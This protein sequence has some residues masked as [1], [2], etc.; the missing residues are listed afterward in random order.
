MNHPAPI[1]GGAHPARRLAM[2][3]AFAACITALGACDRPAEMARADSIRADSIAAADTSYRLRPGYIIDSILPV[4]EELRSFRAGL[5]EPAR[6]SG[7]AD[8]REE[9]VRR[10]IDRLAARDTA[11]LAAMALTRAEF[12]SLIYPSSRYTRPPYRTP[13]GL[14][15][16]RIARRRDAGLTRLLRADQPA[17]RYV[18]HRCAATP[19]VEGQTRLWRECV[20]RATRRAGDTLSSRLFGVIVE[21]DGHFKFTDF[22]N[23]L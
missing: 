8:S 17:L 18:D 20:V 22:D 3:L 6:L 11:A 19:E 13:A 9:L 4:E 15:W 12:A 1:R 23:S 7:G 16:M 21:R 2:R 5:R 14:L 10:F